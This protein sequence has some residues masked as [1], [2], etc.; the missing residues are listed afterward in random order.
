MK[1]K[2]G[3]CRIKCRT[4]LFQKQKKLID[5]KDPLIDRGG[6]VSGN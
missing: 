2:S 3:R 4:L 1:A 5:G 6:T